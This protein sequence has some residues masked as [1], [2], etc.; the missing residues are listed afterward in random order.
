MFSSAS[1]IILPYIS[2]W[3]L[4]LFFSDFCLTTRVTESILVIKVKDFVWINL[5]WNVDILYKKE[6]NNL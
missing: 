4:K 2:I 5:I 1:D 3:K 6:T